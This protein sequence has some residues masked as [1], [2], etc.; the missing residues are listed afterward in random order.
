MTF[1][2]FLLPLSSYFLLALS[3]AEAIGFRLPNQDPD[4]IARGNAFVATADTPSAVYFNPAGITQLEGQN[5]SLGLYAISANVEFTGNGT[6]GKTDSTAQFV[7]Q[8]Y[9]TYSLDNSNWSFGIGVFAPFGLSIDWGDDSPFPSKARNGRLSYISINPVVAYQISD[10]LSLGAGVSLDYAEFEVEQA[11]FPNNL[12]TFEF[13]G[14]GTTVGFNFGLLYQPNKNWSF[15]LN[16]RSATSVELDGDSTVKT[17]IAIAPAFPAAGTYQSNSS[18]NFDLPQNIDI[19]VS[20]RPNED[21]NFEINI[22]WTDFD[23]VNSSI[24]E[25][26]PLGDVSF[27]LNYEASFTY[28]FG[29]TRYLNDGYYISTGYIFS[30][31]SV[32]DE[33]F[34]PLNPDAD[35][36][37]WGIGVG[38]KGVKWS[39]SFG[40]HFAY[41]GG[42]TISGNAPSAAGETADGEYETFNHAVNLALRYKF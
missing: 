34:T 6:S 29:V 4:A 42:K 5:A 37:L 8:L 3:N 21:W 19:G 17:P 40:Y 35:Y 26:T 14:D 30:E 11:L 22:D 2:R 31:Q 12:G 25:A 32:P 23:V 41:N 15:G 13:A 10:E 1:T 38:R 7:P 24:I 16:F 9:Y 20:Y 33:T 36:H 27:P 28:E 39:W 18:A